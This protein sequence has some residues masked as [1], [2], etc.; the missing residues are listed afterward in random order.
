MRI[1][2]L[3]FLSVG[4]II[5]MQVVAPIISFQLWLIGQKHNNLSL[6]SP[7]SNS[8]Q[9]LGVS[10]ENNINF[11]YFVSD[12]KREFPTNYSEFNLWIP[13]LNL[14]KVAVLVDNN[15]LIERLA[16]LPGTALPGEKGNVFISG[17]S[18]VNPFLGVKKAYFAKLNDMK[19][20]DEIL[21]EAKG[22][23]FKYQVIDLKVVDP[24]ETWVIAP[25]ETGGR[26]IT[27]MTC[28]PPGLN[29]K[30]LVVLGKML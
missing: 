11:S 3:G 7:T 5:L 17:H 6:V 14:E 20:G 2:S 28:V 21:L 26:Y 12:I 9:V 19:K 18:A 4:I 16:H 8:A 24:K 29:F 13:R 10:V 25:P 1:L 15:E 30:R 22:I 27:L 23:N